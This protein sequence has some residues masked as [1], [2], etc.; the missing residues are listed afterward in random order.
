[1]AGAGDVYQVRS[2]SFNG[3]P[4]RSPVAPETQIERQIVFQTE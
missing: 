4:N 3:A 1:V 2:K